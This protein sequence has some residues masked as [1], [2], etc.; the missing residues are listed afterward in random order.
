MKQNKI[1]NLYPLEELKTIIEEYLAYNNEENAPL[2]SP[3]CRAIAILRKMHCLEKLSF[4][5]KEIIE[6]NGLI[7]QFKKLGVNTN[8]TQVTIE[9]ENWELRQRKK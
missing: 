6:I 1:L 9:T 7:I 5:K 2:L 8:W 4:L 3:C